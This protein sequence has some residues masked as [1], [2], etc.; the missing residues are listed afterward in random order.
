MRLS[1]ARSEIPE[2]VPSASVAACHEET[3]ANTTTT[4]ADLYMEDGLPAAMLEVKGD[5]GNTPVPKEE[6]V[7]R[8]V[9]VSTDVEV[10]V[11]VAAVAD[12]D[13]L[14]TA[15]EWYGGTR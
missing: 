3:P 14:A 2:E 1:A 6:E 4:I 7:S 9:S 5:D 8:E 12:E 13:E 10:E 11:E 15:G